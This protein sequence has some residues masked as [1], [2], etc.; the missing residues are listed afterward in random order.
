VPIIGLTLI[1]ATKN[2][3]AGLWYPMG[4]AAV[5]AVIC[6]LR[7]PETSHVDISSEASVASIREPAT[8]SS[9]R[10]PSSAD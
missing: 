1:S 7:I 4:I 5:C 8:V 2:N 9:S 3:F 6:Y 10:S